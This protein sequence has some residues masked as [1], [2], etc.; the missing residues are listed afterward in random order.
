MTRRRIAAAL[1]ATLALGGGCWLWWWKAH[2]DERQLEQLAN[3][4]FQLCLSE[5]KPGTATW[6][7][8]LNA[9]LDQY[10]SAPR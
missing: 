5:V 7:A 6:D 8:D 10:R 4:E 2:E 3:I 9:C 1:V